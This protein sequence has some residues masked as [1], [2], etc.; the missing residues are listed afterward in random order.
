MFQK[1]LLK[2]L[3]TGLLKTDELWTKGANNSAIYYALV[4]TQL[5]GTKLGL[6][7]A[8]YPTLCYYLTIATCDVELYLPI[9]LLGRVINADRCT[10]TLYLFLN[11]N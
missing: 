9:L 10:A 5:G 3:H 8:N 6:L 4:N 2:H 7:L 1:K 11:L